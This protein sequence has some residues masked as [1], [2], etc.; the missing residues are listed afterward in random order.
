MLQLMAWIN[1]GLIALQ[2]VSAGFFLSGNGY[3][4]MTHRE[5]ALALQAGA[6]VQAITAVVQWRRR[7]EPARAVVRGAGLLVMVFV[8]SGLGYSHRY[9][10]HVP[11]GVG[12][13][14]WMLAWL[15]ASRGVEPREGPLRSRSDQA[16]GRSTALPAGAQHNRADRSA[17][18]NARWMA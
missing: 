18:A 2:P 3:A 15:T 17:A 9:W 13:F 4:A 11:I 8:Q 6:L 14:G 16:R 10:L 7:R 1:L 5:V 12:M